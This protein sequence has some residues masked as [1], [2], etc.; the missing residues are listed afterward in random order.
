MKKNLNL[1]KKNFLI[2]SIIALILSIGVYSYTLS[3]PDPG[4]GA[5]QIWISVNGIEKTLQEAIVSEDLEKQIT[6]RSN[7][8]Y[9]RKPVNIAHGGDEVIISV[10]GI[11]KTLQEA[12]DDSD[13]IKEIITKSTLP[14]RKII[15]FGSGANNVLLAINGQEKSLQQV[16]D[17]GAFFALTKKLTL[18]KANSDLLNSCLSSCTQQYNNC[19]SGNA[20][21]LW[22]A[23]YGWGCADCNTPKV[24]CDQNCNQQFDSY[25]C[26]NNN[27][28]QSNVCIDNYCRPTDYCQTWSLST[29]LLLGSG[30]IAYFS[31]EDYNSKG[32]PRLGG[33][34]NYYLN[35]RSNVK[36]T[37][38]STF[39]TDLIYFLDLLCNNFGGIGC[40]KDAAITKYA[41][42]R[43][44][45]IPP[46][47]VV[48]SPY[49]EAFNGVGYSPGAGPYGFYWFGP[50]YYS[51]ETG[52]CVTS[53]RYAP[54]FGYGEIDG[55]FKCGYTYNVA[56][57]TMDICAYK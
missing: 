28:C 31:Q 22:C 35:L 45:V 15:K 33:D 48:P 41:G 11:E 34:L 46:S 57:I 27:E 17:D 37:C 16:I 25:K 10:N 47:M 8:P 13:F 52:Y 51:S 20:N 40:Q 50:Y 19:A 53:G 2:I 30:P 32:V 44:T 23:W 55:I 56:G 42:N 18:D 36:Q 43:C 1:L 9:I 39:R 54:Q 12:V 5:D 14:Y 7:L 21:N 24:T 4:H 6:I 3:L 26:L 29:N 38:E 49:G